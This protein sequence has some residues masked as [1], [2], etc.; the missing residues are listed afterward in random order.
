MKAKILEVWVERDV[1]T[2][3]DLSYLGAYSDRA[4]TEWA[5]DRQEW[6]N[7]ERDEYH[8]W[9]PCNHV[10]PGRKENWAHVSSEDVQKAL[11]QANLEPAASRALATERLD[12]IYIK[13]D[14]Q[15]HESYNRGD[16]CMLGIIAKATVQLTSKGP[17]QTLRS[18]GLWG[19]E[20]D[21]E[22]D[23][24]ATVEREELDDLRRQLEAVGF[25]KR[26]VDYA[27][28]KVEREEE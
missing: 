12:L 7:A 22:E 13:Q 10:P 14:Y 4:E 26:A 11:S 19:I 25:G 18:G 17:V 28:R 16:W 5:I 24:F 6:G 23:Y 21:S 20:S 9:N 8:Y 2:D 27:F 3:P 15:R 1:D